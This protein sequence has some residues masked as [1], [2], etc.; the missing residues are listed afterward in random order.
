M[1]DRTVS[2][3]TSPAP[4]ATAPGRFS[5]ISAATDGGVTPRVV[6]LC[7]ALAV[8]FGYVIPVIDVQM[9]NTFL[10][11]AHLPPGSIAALLIFLLVIN[12][13]L[14]FVAGRAERALPLLF[15]AIACGAGAALLARHSLVEARPIGGFGFWFLIAIGLLS[16]TCFALRR[17]PLSR[18]ELLTVYITT[19]FSTL[20]PGH[21][22]ENFFVSN[23]IG[24]FYFATPEN[25]WLEF[26]TPNLPSWMTPAL[27]GGDGA[28]SDAAKR[29]IQD[30]YS[31]N[32]GNVP[33]HFWTVPLLAWG[34]FIFVSYFMLGCL[35]II[36]RA[37]WAER[38]ALAFPL[39]RLPLELTEDVDRPEEGVV[40]RFFRNP[41]MWIGFGVAV[42]IQSLRGLHV[43]FPDVPD[44]PLE[45]PLNAYFSDAPWNQLGWVPMQVYPIAVGITYLLTSEVS[46]SMWF[47]YWFIRFELIMAYYMG[48]MPNTLPNLVGHV[49]GAKTFNGYQQIGAYLAY[50]ALVSW[51]G[52][53]HLAHVA[54][55]AFG[56]APTGE[57]ESREALSYPVA[58]WGFVASF[59]FMMAWSMAAGMDFV[60]ALALWITYLV[61]A[62]ALTRIVVEGGLLF[63][64]QGWTSLGAMA[65]VAGSGP[66][67]WLAP[68]S[69]VPGAFLQAAMI[70]DLRAF[71]MPSFIQSFKL[72]HD[73]QL[74]VKPLFWLIMSVVLITLV[75]GIY[76]NVYSGYAKGGL[77][78]EGWFAQ[79]GA[80][81]PAENANN[82]IK[83]SPDA[84]WFNLTWIG[85][86]AGLTFLMM[87][88]RSR[89]LWFPLHPIGFLMCLTYPMQRL[90][91][92]IFLGWLC[93]GLITR[94]G[95]TVVYRQATPLFLGLALG[96]V[97]MMLF[98]LIID[99]WQGHQF[100]Q[101]MPG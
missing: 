44:F 94:F 23:L 75:M 43:Y 71:L 13:L 49:G 25:K 51:T 57:N 26:L 5:D 69:L 55:R 80:K 87:L 54:R 38:E 60:P 93:K 16:L 46:F 72:A 68:N 89:F 76:M 36:L 6:G 83:G 31:G 14:H 45:I 37:Q 79:G 90:W 63:V 67:T 97:S 20:V 42:A 85:I 21:G 86:G 10:G 34:V 15:V 95:G 53:E 19:L 40:G 74:K 11:A 41:L 66:G 18:N 91:F 7:L 4:G 84:S 92:S 27:W 100:H 2:S 98:W 24:P 12:P 81:Q 28:F 65:Q 8:C 17:R 9:A 64:Q 101:L 29:A 82:L 96:D 78:L 1:A 22:A 56:R 59:A 58:F 30:W 35:C 50:V 48:F 77:T 73:R 88:A 39:L 62:I 32:G 61:A 47:F 3:A 99:G 52:R 33:W 70:T